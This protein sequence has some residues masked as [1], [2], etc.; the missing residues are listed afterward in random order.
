L[1]GF[2]LFLPL[3]ADAFRLDFQILVGTELFDEQLVL[4][5]GDFG[6]RGQFN[7]ETFLAKERGYRL[8][9]YV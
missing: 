4:F 2:F 9:T 3:L 7:L 1:G 8:Y 5:V 6:V